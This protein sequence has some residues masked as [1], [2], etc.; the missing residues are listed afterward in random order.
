MNKEEVVFPN[1]STIRFGDV[2]EF[3]SVLNGDWTIKTDTEWVLPEDK[4]QGLPTFYFLKDIQF[5][6]STIA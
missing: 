3:E 2:E 5:I 6:S 4:L 1:G